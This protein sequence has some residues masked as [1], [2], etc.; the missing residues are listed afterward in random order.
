MKKIILITLFALGWAILS[1]QVVNIPDTNFKQALIEDGV[2]VN[3]DGEIQVNEVDTLKSLTISGYNINDLTG[4]EAFPSLSYLNCSDNNIGS[5]NLNDLSSLNRL[6]ASNNSLLSIEIGA[7]SGLKVL[8]VDENPLKELLIDED[9]GIQSIRADNIETTYLMLSNLQ[10]LDYLTYSS[11]Y[12][13]REN[14]DTLILENLPNLLSFSINADMYKLEINNL[15]A[16]EHF[17]S[18]SIE[19]VDI[20]HCS[21]VSEVLIA[22]HNYSDDARI[23]ISDLPQLRRLSIEGS[24][25]IDVEADFNSFRLLDSL[26]ISGGDFNLEKLHLSNMDFLR[27]LHIEGVIVDTFHLEDL[28]L[29]KRLNYLDHN[30]IEVMKMIN[31]PSL[32]FMRPR[33]DLFAFMPR[34]LKSV[35]F[36]RLPL[37]DSLEFG[38]DHLNGELESFILRDLPSLKHLSLDRYHGEE[39]DLRALPGL[40][41][42]SLDLDSPD[43]NANQDLYFKNGRN[44]IIT[45]DFH[46]RNYLRI[47]AD[48]IEL[49][50][51]QSQLDMYELDSVEMTTAC[52]ILPGSGFYLLNG[53]VIVDL[54]DNGCDENDLGLPGVHIT[55]IF[56]NEKNRILSNSI[57]GYALYLEEGT[58]NLKLKHNEDYY[59]WNTDSL[60][61][62]LP[63]DSNSLDFDF[64]LTPTGDIKDLSIKIIPTE[65]LRP[66]FEAEFLLKYKNEG[67]TIQ[68]GEIEFRY[69]DLYCDYISSNPTGIDESGKV[70]WNFENLL[71][72]EERKIIIV[73]RFNSPMDDPPLNGGDAL[74]FGAN[75]FPIEGDA[76]PSNNIHAIKPILVNSYDPND[77]TCLQGK[78]IT[79]EMVG[80]YVDYLIRFENTGT[81][82]AVNIVVRDRI[83]TNVFEINTFTIIDASHKMETRISEGNL[84]EFIFEEIYLPFDDANNDGYISFS[85]K[86]KDDLVL[87]DKL[88]NT[89]EIYFDFNWP[90]ITNTATTEVREPVF[91]EENSNELN[92]K[93]YPNPA[94]DV[95]S[96]ECNETI[97][98]ISIFDAG[99]KI[100]KFA[101]YLAPTK[102][103]KLSVEGLMP[104]NYLLRIV[105]KENKSVSRK[106]L[107]E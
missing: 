14:R 88:E 77:K 75:I 100:I 89:A 35:H 104:G 3:G 52:S 2:D 78:E 65:E 26:S 27:T 44:T 74:G 71:P 95:I 21:K 91:I 12:D 11:I 41:R 40:E 22:S 86:T 84:V 81:A 34:D 6:F 43:N 36:E 51:I 101:D 82:E 106:I 55:Q 19:L 99:G 87:G 45:I 42:L 32:R 37:V 24:L 68:S 96:L 31:L 62:E 38:F 66:G 98:N 63:R 5:I 93:I 16:L 10:S 97:D 9:S 7:S 54:D 8:D 4:I 79:P 67:T 18:T 76:K 102:H 64:C 69:T 85:I 58:S 20:H 13:Y 61:I 17:Y 28:Y 60:S 70:N 94:F 39:L 50:Q 59:S 47:C 72:Q 83:D 90:I 107:I 92:L 33:E 80:E 49:E 30:Q 15:H 29:L 103:T 53:K 105:S 57:G 73:L 46:D 25:D 56:E 23:S 1:A 48:S